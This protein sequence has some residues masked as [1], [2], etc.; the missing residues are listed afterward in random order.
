MTKI[1]FVII[2]FKIILLQNIAYS[3]QKSDSL[4]VYQLG[5]I[6]VTGMGSKSS[7]SQVNINTLNY[8]NIQKSDVSSA[9]ELQLYIPSARIRTNSR[10]ESMLFLRGSGERQLG[11]FFDGV[12]LN[13]AWDNRFDLSMLPTDIIG[14]MD[15]NKNSNS[16]IYGA[17]VMGGAISISTIEKANDGYGANMRLQGG[18][19][20]LY[21][22]AL[23][24]D[25]RAGNFNYL[26]SA[27]KTQNDA[28]TIS[29]KR[30][31]SLLNQNNNSGLRDNT[32]RSFTNLYSRIEYNFDESAKLGLSVLNINGEKGVAPETHIENA[33]FWRYPEWNRTI[34][35][36][37]ASAFLN[38]TGN[39]RLRTTAW[40]DV[41]HQ[42]INS[43]SDNNYD[44][45]FQKQK[46]NDITLGARIALVWDLHRNHLFQFTSNSYYTSHEEI[47]DNNSPLNYS[48]SVF[49]NGLSYEYNINKFD[50]STGIVYDYIVT[51][52]SGVFEDYQ[53]STL[54]D[55]GYYAS[56]KYGF[57]DKTAIF[58]NYSLRTRFPTLRESYSGALDRFV[59]NPN[60]KPETGNLIEIGINRSTFEY[61]S[62]FSLFANLYDGLIEQIR[63]SKEQDEL[64]RRMRIN[65]SSADIWGAD[66][67][68]RFYPLNNFD[69]DVNFTY[70]Y[71]SG[72]QDS[73]KLDKI[74]NRPEFLTG[75]I[76][77]Y[78][79]NFGLTL[80]GEFESTGKQYER[81]PDDISRFVEIGA[82]SIINFRLSY[83]FNTN[84]ISGES[85]ELFAR[86]NNIADTYR[87]SQL[88]LPEQGRVLLA[89][90][91]AHI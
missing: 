4:K 16:I 64:R 39:L 31:D 34:F 72:Y 75:V 67:S 22:Y 45:V 18:S 21:Q 36:I 73:I 24:H 89:G 79:Y 19:A 6:S 33:R 84:L 58:A 70:L 35:A 41:N 74:D 63:I 27:G 53:N 69:V 42:Q 23:T 83:Q 28:F 66:L 56:I 14:K 90:F 71:A 91:K 46:D 29:D 76:L 65:Y 61:T 3:S 13:V 5:D 37:N 60:L 47:I 59:A 11:L 78:K 26:I 15:I 25:G 30:P 7:I 80:Q 38:S 87:I 32:F 86:V 52:N 44:S 81:S 62:E 51:G 57:D 50:L 10:G 49:S 12:P 9:A 54:G 77:K 85:L 55:Y 1:Y 68:L 40:Y 8:F 20:G 48:Q 88:G 17:N 2:I 82:T 43:Y